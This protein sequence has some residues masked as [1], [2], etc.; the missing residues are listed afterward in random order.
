MIKKIT[1]W[2]IRQYAHDRNFRLGVCK[3]LHYNA[4]NYFGDQSVPGR[5]QEACEEFFEA[6]IGN[7]QQEFPSIPDIAQNYVGGVTHAFERTADK[8]QGFA[9]A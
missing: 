1:L 4:Q 2:L 3:E 9:F 8:M 5:F 6:G 7:L